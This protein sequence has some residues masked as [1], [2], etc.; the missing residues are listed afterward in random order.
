MTRTPITPN[1]LTTARLGTGLA[2][3]AM[4]S[5]GQDFW[6]YFASGAFVLSIILDRADGALA[7]LSSKTSLWGHKY[8]LL[9]DAICNSLMFVGIGIGLRESDLGLWAVP[10]GIL[11]GLSV[12]AILF[13]VILAEGHNGI[14]A[15]ELKGTKG[16]D[17]DDAILLVPVAMVIGWG[18]YLIVAAAIGA[19]F[20]SLFFY[21]KF[22][23]ILFTTFRFKK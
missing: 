19:L 16:I 23:N 1:H 21:W 11:A 3:A 10:L 14:R 12:A 6:T 4:Y 13:L 17:P 18:Y 20:F 22:R 2:A 15:A 9:S 7:R 5:I 8:D